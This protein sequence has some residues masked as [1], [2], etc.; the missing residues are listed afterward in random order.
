MEMILLSSASYS[1]LR[2]EVPDSLH[3]KIRGVGAGT[4]DLLRDLRRIEMRRRP[5]WGL[6]L[7]SR[8]IPPKQRAAPQLRREVALPI[9]VSSMASHVLCHESQTTA[10][11]L[12]SA[13]LL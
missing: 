12:C 3:Y 6:R 4:P 11:S 13:G 9:G 8:S 10:P 7:P 2:V 5:L 1:R